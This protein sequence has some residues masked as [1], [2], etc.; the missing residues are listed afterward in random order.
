VGSGLGLAVLD[1]V[2]GHVRLRRS[3][4]SSIPR[5]GRPGRDPLLVTSAK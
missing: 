1:G 3:I 5:P 2:S 4:P